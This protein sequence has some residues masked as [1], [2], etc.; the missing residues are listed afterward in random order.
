MFD[1]QLA[2]WHLERQGYFAAI[3]VNLGDDDMVDVFGVKTTT[4]EPAVFGVVRGWWHT[5]AYLTPSLIRNHLQTDRHLL[6]RAFAPER[7]AQAQTQFGLDQPPDKVIF[8]SKR[9]P[10]LAAEAEG[11]LQL[12]GIRAVYL[13]D[14]LA[15]ALAEVRYDDRGGGTIFAVLAMVK[16]SRIFKEMARLARQ[17]ERQTEKKKAD[18]VRPEPDE[19]DQQLDLLLSMP[20]EEE[21]EGVSE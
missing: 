8:Y 17:V 20:E 12:L 9:S 14:I 13:E 6:D 21:D 16:G 19:T 4:N 7:L 3:D 1:R 2:K 15:A 10:S 18:K 11:E 5:G